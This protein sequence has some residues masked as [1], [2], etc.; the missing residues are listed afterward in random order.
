M[1]GYLQAHPRSA[2][3]LLAFVVHAMWL[4]GTFLSDDFGLILD[5]TEA[6]RPSLRRALDG[7][8]RPLP[9]VEA[10]LPPDIVARFWRPV[11]R[12]SFYLDLRLWGAR[13]FGFLLTNVALHVG[14]V[15]LLFGVVRRLGLGVGA[16]WAASAMF[17]VYPTHHEAVPWIAARCGPLALLFSLLCAELLLASIQRADSID[18]RRAAGAAGALLA[19][20]LADPDLTTLIRICIARIV[21]G[22][23]PRTV[24]GLADTILIITNWHVR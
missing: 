24:G 14:C 1:I 4:R 20:L 9:G 8:V 12:L 5:I 17:A 2:L 19:A 13:P 16:A 3:A 15:V 23:P 22:R 7:F 21:P 6:G 18:R 10:P 11:W